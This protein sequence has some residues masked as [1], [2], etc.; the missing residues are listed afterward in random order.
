LMSHQDSP[1][2]EGA[3]VAVETLVAESIQKL[4]R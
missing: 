2:L 3:R 1:L 4:K